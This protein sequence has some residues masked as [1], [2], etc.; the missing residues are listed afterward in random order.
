ARDREYGR[1]EL[2]LSRDCGALFRNIPRRSVSW[3]S[4]GDYVARLPKGFV[5]TGYTKN[6][7]TA[8]CEDHARRIYGVQFHPEVAHSE[9][10]VRV[11]R[12]FLF[13]VCRFKKSWTMENFIH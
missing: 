10:G 7:H 12:N 1:A 2:F 8:S 4:H 3:M 11:I 13:G 6:T 5:K 9:Y